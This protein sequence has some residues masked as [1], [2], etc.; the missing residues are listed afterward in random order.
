MDVDVRP[1][2]LRQEE[3]G[4]ILH[5]E[6]SEPMQGV[7]FISPAKFQLR[8]G[9]TVQIEGELTVPL[10]KTNYVSF[11][12]LVRDQGQISGGDNA[13][14]P[15][16]GTRAAIR[17]VTQ[18][19]LRVDVETGA[20][21]VGDMDRLRFDAGRLVERQGLPHVEAYLNN[22]TDFALECQV[23][24][25]LVAADGNDSDPIRLNMPSRSEL[26][27]DGRYL[28]RIMPRSRLRLE[29]ALD[30]GIQSGNYSLNLQ[31]SNTRR[32]MVEAN[33]PVDVDPDRFLGLE[34]KI[35]T[36]SSGLSIQPAQME[37]GRIA[38]TE[39]MSTLL[40]TNQG[41]QDCTV[42]LVPRDHAGK[43]MENVVLSSKKFVVKSGRSKSVRAI[44]RGMDDS[45]S[46]WG[47]IEV[48]CDR[49]ELMV[50]ESA[51]T[52]LA[53]SLIHQSRPAIDLVADELQWAKLPTGN[54]FVLRIEN[55]GQG[56]APLYGLLKLAAQE[57]LPAEMSDGF[58]KWLAPGES[59]E[60]KFMVSPKTQ[61]GPHQI[62]LDVRSADDQVVVQRTL[63]LELTEEMLQLPE[64][65]IALS[66]SR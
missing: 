34:S 26:D 17:F 61:P 49:G 64:D 24:A 56:Y 18:Y 2:N 12:I 1:I 16:G 55:Q 6:Q 10:N 13:D 44:L 43:P 23:R 8:P 30:G 14:L 59:R 31:L 42:R 48:Q 7:R 20:Q 22:P 58:G 28:I 65:Q 35:V 57:G 21:D 32:T 9:E 53:L 11:G 46:Q 38:G 39:R 41:E 51:K 19:V 15:A 54:A 40:L 37:L 60:L 27:D 4:I 36:L 45:D 25:K 63:V 29:G 62:T 52:A 33:F 47:T 50:A 3:T 66:R 5:D